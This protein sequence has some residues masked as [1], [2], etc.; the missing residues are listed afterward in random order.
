MSKHAVRARGLRL[1]S[2]EGPQ[3]K[4]VS[5]ILVLTVVSVPSSKL[6]VMC[7]SYPTLS[8]GRS[9]WYGHGPNPPLGWTS[10]ARLNLH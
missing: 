8:K 4:M 10:K 5:I 3:D 6:Y 9:A 7:P 1:M 2:D